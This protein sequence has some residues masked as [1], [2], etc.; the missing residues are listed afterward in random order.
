M[1]MQKMSINIDRDI[2]TI[3]IYL[4]KLRDVLKVYYSVPI[5]ECD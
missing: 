3:Q 2:V 5:Q 4:Y 1:I